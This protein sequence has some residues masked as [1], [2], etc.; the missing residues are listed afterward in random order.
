MLAVAPAVAVAP[1][2]RAVSQLA[3]ALAQRLPR[4]EVASLTGLTYNQVRYW[5]RKARDNRF[6]AGPHGGSRTW[7]LTAVDH[8]IAE[9]VLLTVL[10]DN[11]S[12]TLRHLA[13]LLG[14]YGLPEL[15][16][17][18]VA[19]TLARWQYSH[20]RL[21]HVQHAKHTPVNIG[22]YINHIFGVINYDPTTLKYL[23]ES[24]FETRS[25]RPAHGFGPSGQNS[26]VRLTDDFR[27][28]FTFTALVSLTHQQPCWV[29]PPRSATNDRWDFL[30]V[31]TQLLADGALVA[32]DT[33]ILDNARVHHAQETTPMVLALFEIHHVQLR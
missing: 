23:D 6:H 30:R 12:A 26:E 18:W 27:E 31:I 32:G 3:G 15:N 25:C 29:S 13:R 28:S 14:E 8:S 19:R 1:E 5:E 10:E 24:R 22:R 33:L 20:K 4:A 17:E 21:Y 16:K 9:A 7:T 2:R 11:P